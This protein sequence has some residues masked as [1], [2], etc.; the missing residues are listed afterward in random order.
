V[1]FRPL[2]VTGGADIGL[3]RRPCKQCVE[4]TNDGLR[5]LNGEGARAIGCAHREPWNV[6]GRER[7]EVR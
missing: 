7:G 6:M 3:L 5:G 1:K 2:G 4:A